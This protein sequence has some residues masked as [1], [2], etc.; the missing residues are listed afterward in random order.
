M[1][2]VQRVCF[3]AEKSPPLEDNRDETGVGDRVLHSLC[4]PFKMQN[5]THRQSEF[6]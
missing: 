3:L 1:T 5:I 6:I 2:D 4:L